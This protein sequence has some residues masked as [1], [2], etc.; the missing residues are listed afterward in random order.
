MKLPPLSLWFGVSSTLFAAICVVM[1]LR[2][3]DRVPAPYIAGG[4]A[5][6]FAILAALQVRQPNA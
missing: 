6:M 4:L 1:L 5:V 2:H 3:I